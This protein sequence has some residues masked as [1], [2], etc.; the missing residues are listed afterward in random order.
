MKPYKKHTVLTSMMRLVN[1]PVGSVLLIWF[2]ASYNE[3]FGA[4]RALPE[5]ST[6]ICAFGSSR[7][8]MEALSLRSLCSRL[9]QGHI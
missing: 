5:S 6:R 9:L 4:M 8:M 2:R 7:R 1:A 3:M